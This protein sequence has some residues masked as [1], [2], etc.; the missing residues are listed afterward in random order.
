VTEAVLLSD[1]VVVL[2]GTPATVVGTE[3]IA[4][5]RPRTLATLDDESFLKH[6][7]RLR[8]MMRSECWRQVQRNQLNS[9]HYQ[10]EILIKG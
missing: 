1:R 5:P 8:Q 2:G 10:T 4:I 6:A 9:L 7:K 3:V